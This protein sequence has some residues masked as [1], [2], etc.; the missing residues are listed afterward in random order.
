MDAAVLYERHGG[1]LHRYLLSRLRDPHDAQ[2]ALQAT[3]LRAVASLGRTEPRDPR[4]WLFAIA[5][6]VV[7]DHAR[8]TAATVEL[9][10]ARAE[11]GPALADR[12]ASRLRL[13]A[14][15]ADLGELP[16]RQRTA[17]VLRELGAADYAEIAARLGMSE[18]AAR[19]AVHEA[20]RGLLEREAGREAPCA[21]IT[22]SL[23]A[24]NGR[25]RRGLRVSAHLAH[26]RSC[27]ALAGRGPLLALP[28]PLAAW[29]RALAAALGGTKAVVAAVSLT[30]ALS[31]ATID[32]RMDRGGP[33]TG[34]AAASVPAAR[35][36]APVPQDVVRAMPDA[37]AR[38]RQ[39]RPAGSLST[40]TRPLS[41]RPG[42]GSP[43]AATAPA[44]AASPERRAPAHE[45]TRPAAAGGPAPA[46]TP[47]GIVIG[48]GQEPTSGPV[49]G[50]SQEPRE[51]ARIGQPGE[52]V[53]ICP[54]DP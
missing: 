36:A 24:G 53:Q 31:L 28:L 47:D 27:R 39:R 7:A 35:A 29:L 6:N 38:A 44:P 19:R 45:D 30:A 41:T 5:R 9:E 11:D 3:W 46:P 25:T 4:A 50:Q 32:A 20:R 43:S 33:A 1:E 52:P 37:R 48:Q 2:D 49:V 15:V 42:A 22:R 13:A 26:C 8:R 12:V 54:C 23:M 40:A 14:V 34:S 18:P 21:E 16:D 17:L 51:V 10:D